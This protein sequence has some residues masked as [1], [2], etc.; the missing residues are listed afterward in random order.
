MSDG[1]EL[2]RYD[3]MCHA[4]AAAHAVDEVKDIRDKARAIEMIAA[5]EHFPR[6][7]LPHLPGVYVLDD[8]VLGTVFYVGESYNLKRRLTSHPRRYLY[9]EGARLRVIFCRNHKRVEKWLIEALKPSL[10][11]VSEDRRRQKMRAPHK[12]AEQ[13]DREFGQMWG[14]L[15]GDGT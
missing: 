15:F 13:A 6:L 4:I 1:T 5:A 3:A 10:N 9:M 8:M 7:W 14:E 2:V 12:T 11:G